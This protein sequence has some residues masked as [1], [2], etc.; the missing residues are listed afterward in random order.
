MSQRKGK[1]KRNQ[2]Q[3]QEQSSYNGW[4]FARDF[5][6]NVFSLLNTGKIFPVIILA[7]LIMMGLMIWR[8]PEEKLPDLVTGI[9]FKVG[10]N[11]L[12]VFSLLIITNIAWYL[13]FRVQ[14]QIYEKE[15]KRLSDIRSILMHGDGVV[16][17]IAE[18]RSS[19][20]PQQE[21]YIFP[22]PTET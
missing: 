18:H 16:D 12:I 7:F 3:E 1:N 17:R 4:Q 15:I 21:G 5:F 13:V 22:N 6:D 2:S 8:Y 20:G 11:W 14:K 9:L 10:S 19:N